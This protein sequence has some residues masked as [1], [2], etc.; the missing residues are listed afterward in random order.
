MPD[1]KFQANDTGTTA[2]VPVGRRF[3]ILLEEN[4]T[5]GYRW[6]EPEFDKACLRLES[7]DYVSH[8][9]GG[10]GGGGIRQFKF[11]V[12]APCRTTIHLVNKRSWETNAAPQ[13]RFE[14]TVV[15]TS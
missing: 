3:Q 13:K 8:Q 6:L 9:G 14:L 11:S 10:I 2:N 4:P 1:L 15:G 7:A 12:T 5:T